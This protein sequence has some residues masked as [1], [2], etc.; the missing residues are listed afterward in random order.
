MA[1]FKIFKGESKNFGKPDSF[2]SKTKEGYA[3]FTPDDGKFYIDI[4]DSEEVIVGTSSSENGANRICIN[5]GSVDFGN[6]LILNCGTAT[7]VVGE[8]VTPSEPVSILYFDC[9]N[10]ASVITNE[11]TIIGCGNSNI[12]ETT[13]NT[14][15]YD[16]GNSNL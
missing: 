12:Q 13:T 6:I 15:F 16:C 11:T 3:Y 8:V 2:T 7:T 9:G 14:I 1:L 5:S 10:S 4:E